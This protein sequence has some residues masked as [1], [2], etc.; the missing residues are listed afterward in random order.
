MFL[1][2]LIVSLAIVSFETRVRSPS[3]NSCII[4]QCVD[5]Q[6]GQFESCLISRHLVSQCKCTIITEFE[7]CHTAPTLAISTLPLIFTK[8][9]IKFSIWQNNF[10]LLI[11]CTN[12]GPDTAESCWFDVQFWYLAKFIFGLCLGLKALIIGIANSAIFWFEKVVDKGQ[13]GDD[14]RF[15]YKKNAKSLAD[16]IA[17][18]SWALNW[19]LSRS[20]TC[21]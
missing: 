11:W 17:A 8:P 20:S 9:C 15:L 21:I 10:L 5:K 7:F 4:P 6:K 12:N 3:K 14:K 1:F 19:C 13:Y 2:S 16:T 18:H